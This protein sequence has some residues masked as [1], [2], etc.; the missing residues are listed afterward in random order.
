MK[1]D[2][3][4]FKADI[5][6]M[7]GEEFRAKYDAET[8]DKYDAILT[9]LIQ[10]GGRRIQNLRETVRANEAR[11]AANE[12]EMR[13]QQMG[14]ED[15]VIVAGPDLDEAINDPDL[16]GWLRVDVY[17]DEV[18]AV[19]LRDEKT[20]RLSLPMLIEEYGVANVHESPSNK[21]R[22]KR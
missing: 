4:Q 18:S 21:Y 19:F 8:R 22:F 17:D 16:K 11:I 1:V 13:Q 15:V 9:V 12:A 5:N 10:E 2:M 14:D 20:L 7:T 3:I 6:T